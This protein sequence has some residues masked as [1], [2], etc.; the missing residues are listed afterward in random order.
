MLQRLRFSNSKLR[1]QSDDRQT[2][3]SDL[4]MEKNISKALRA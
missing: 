2:D 4:I 3:A 1:P